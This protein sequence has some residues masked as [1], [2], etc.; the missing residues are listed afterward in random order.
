[1]E[2]FKL[3]RQEWVSLNRVRTGHGICGSS[4]HQ[5]KFRDSSACDDCGAMRPRQFN[6]LW[7]TVLKENSK[8]KWMISLDYQ[9]KLLIGQP[10]TSD[11]REKIELDNGQYKLILWSRWTLLCYY[12]LCMNYFIFHFYLYSMLQLFI[13]IYCVS[14]TINKLYKSFANCSL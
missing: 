4:M 14:N 12:Y 9:V 6:T 3:P 13:H 11:C 1:M 8:V 10:S 7:Q 2:G 5:W